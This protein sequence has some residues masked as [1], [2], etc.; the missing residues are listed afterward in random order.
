MALKNCLLLLVA[1][2]QYFKERIYPSL[3][4]ERRPVFLGGFKLEGIGGLMFELHLF[5]LQLARPIFH[6][7]YIST[8]FNLTMSGLLNFSLASTIQLLCRKRS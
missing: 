2:M 5:F 6:P 1:F 4:L 3:L 7:S 8:D